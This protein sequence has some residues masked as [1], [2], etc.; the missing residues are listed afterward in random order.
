MALKLVTLI[1]AAK[2][3]IQLSEMKNPPLRMLLGNPALEMLR[4]KLD[5][6]I[7]EV[8]KNEP[9]TRSADFGPE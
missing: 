3:I 2:I 9:I 1:K 8:N 7:A 5:K 6:F 4:E